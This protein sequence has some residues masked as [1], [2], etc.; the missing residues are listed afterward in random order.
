VT[1]FSD[2]LS[3]TLKAVR[4]TI[5]PNILQHFRHT[6]ILATIGPSTNSYDMI[7]DAI[8]H[9]AR[10]LRLNFSHGTHEEKAQHIKWARKASKE[11]DIPVAIVQDLQGPKIRLGDFDGIAT[12]KRGDAVQ[13]GYKSNYDET[14]IFPTQ[15]DLA[16]KVK[17]GHRILLA[18]GRIHTRVTAVRSGKVYAEVIHGG[19]LSS[20]K[21]INLP[22]TDFEGDVLTAKDKK[23]IAFGAEHDIDYIA[24]SFVQRAADIEQLRKILKKQGSSARI[25]AKIE[26]KP[27]LDD[28]E[29]IIKTADA[30]MVAR[31]D[32]AVEV[33]PEAVPIWQ[34]KIMDLATKHRKVVI[35][36]TQMLLSMVHST[37]PTRAE[38]SDIATAT[39]LGADALM[40]S[41]ETANGHYPLQAVSTMAQIIRYTERNSPYEPVLF[42]HDDTSLQTAVSSAIVTLAHQVK[43][44]AIV[45]E[46]ATGRTAL[47]IAS[48]RP[49]VPI[50][51]ITN[52]RRVMNQM[53]LLYGSLPFTH[54]VDRRAATK[55][56]DWMV[57][58]KA[59]NKGDRIVT[60]SG[61]SPGVSG[62]TD[63]IK[64]RVL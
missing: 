59:F 28:I 6:K 12:L 38:A 44:T 31:G 19:E 40:L 63:T 35:V 16:P 24:Q 49:K 27:A 30:V 14:G 13:F 25:I 4:K 1:S 7:H 37:Q 26:T 50:V 32:L 33:S 43:A 20:K 36:A 42:V 64:I 46:T 29:A 41:E 39:I 48:R 9:G 22:D 3:V 45:A 23:D 52:D 47:N 8:T 61:G 55:L 54:P 18:D 53:A 56:T 60:A 58:M 5:D 34:R 17:P 21:G 10:G 51:V 15:Y 57:E 11:L 62:G 2:P